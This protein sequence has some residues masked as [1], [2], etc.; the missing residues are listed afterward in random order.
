MQT[1]IVKGANEAYNHVLKRR[2]TWHS[3][4]KSNECKF[5]RAGI[6]TAAF[7]PSYLYLPSSMRI[8]LTFHILHKYQ[9]GLLHFLIRQES[10]ESARSILQFPDSKPN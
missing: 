2:R 8:L 3:G 5:Q 10:Q 9:I 1:G 4:A 6:V 7:V